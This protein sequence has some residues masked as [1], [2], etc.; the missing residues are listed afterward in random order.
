MKSVVLEE[1]GVSFGKLKALIDVSIRASAG[2]VLMLAGPNGAGKSTLMRVLLGLVRPSSGQLLVDDVATQVNHRFKAQL[3]YLPEAVAFSENLTGSQVLRFFAQARGVDRKRVDAVL[4]RVGLTQA[5]RRRV[6][7]YSRGMRQ[8]LG[9]AVAILTEPALLV[10]D[11][12]TGGLDQE[13]LELLWSVLSE[14]RESERVVIMATH[15]LT[16]VE[17]RVDCVCVL[18]AGRR[19]AFDSPSGLRRKVGLPLTVTF[20]VVDDRIDEVAERI[21]RW[22]RAELDREDGIVR[23]SVSTEDLLDLMDLRANL[24]GAVRSLRVEEPG[25]DEV[26]EA[27]LQ[28]GAA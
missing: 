24:P 2:E 17:R 25:M 7:G 1:V 6:R 28:R 27:L 4:E 13:G 8:R 20:E 12:P 18:D 3:G 11:E 16:L 10:L 22:G 5:S 19:V 23:V 14:W 15:D 21:E 26:Y 9:I